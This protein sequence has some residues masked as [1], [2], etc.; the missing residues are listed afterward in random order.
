MNVPSFDFRFFL[1]RSLLF[2]AVILDNTATN[3]GRKNGLVACLERKLGR[4]IHMVGCMLHLNELPLRHLIKELDGATISGNKLAGP[5]GQKLGDDFYKE[6]PV[7]FEP[8]PTTLERPPARVVDDLSGDQRI[9]LEYMLGR[10]S[11][12]FV[13]SVCNVKNDFFLQDNSRQC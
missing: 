11:Q 7:D 4:K 13:C 8:V 1:N 10:G 3:T 12:F 5:I 6:T 9:L 2:Q